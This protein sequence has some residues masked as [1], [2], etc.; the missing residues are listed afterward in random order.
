MLNIDGLGISRN[1]P[2]FAEAISTTDD[3]DR[4]EGVVE[5]DHTSRKFWR[6]LCAIDRSTNTLEDV[7]TDGAERA[8]FA[9]TGPD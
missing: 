9:P 3:S 5:L 2:V 7:A 6:F 8:M 4:R 1:A